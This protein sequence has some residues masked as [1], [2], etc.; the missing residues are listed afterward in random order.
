MVGVGGAVSSSLYLERQRSSLLLCLA[1]Y[2]G[3]SVLEEVLY[4]S[5]LCFSKRT[6]WLD[7]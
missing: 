7:I 3:Q 1:L 4:S 2:V 5:R 6:R